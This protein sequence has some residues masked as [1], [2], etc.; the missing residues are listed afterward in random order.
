M[1]RLSIALAL[2]VLIASTA[3]RAQGRHMDR[4]HRVHPDGSGLQRRGLGLGQVPADQK[5]ISGTATITSSCVADPQSATFTF[6]TE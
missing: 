2:G 5:V 1:P 4:A 6:T 3:P